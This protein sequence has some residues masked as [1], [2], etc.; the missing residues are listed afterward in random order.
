MKAKKVTVRHNPS[1]GPRKRTMTRRHSRRVSGG[2][3]VYTIAQMFDAFATI[4]DLG[5]LR[6]KLRAMADDDKLWGMIEESQ[7]VTKNRDA[8]ASNIEKKLRPYWK[9]K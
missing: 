4:E 7:E 6:K 2:Y 8:L 3:G 9:S 1:S 5:I